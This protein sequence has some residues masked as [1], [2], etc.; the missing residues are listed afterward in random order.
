VQAPSR[1]Q[2]H[3][4]RTGKAAT[5]AVAWFTLIASS[6]VDGT[7]I[8]PLGWLETVVRSVQE[9]TFSIA[10][11]TTPPGYTKQ[12]H[13]PHHT[14]LNAFGPPHPLSRCSWDSC[15]ISPGGHLPDCSEGSCHPGNIDQ[16]HFPHRTQLRGLGH[17]ADHSEAMP[18]HGT[19]PRMRP[20][21]S[22]HPNNL[23]VSGCHGKT[24]CHGP[25]SCCQHRLATALWPTPHQE[26]AAAAAAAAAA[27]P[28]RIP[29]ASCGAGGTL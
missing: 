11:K 19:H 29:S 7:L 8:Q 23:A 4:Q 26:T 5:A 12:T 16:T 15:S 14:R 27:R 22:P 9:G 18:V 24:C 28:V 25:H 13:F 1:Q 20:Q 17:R 6:W 10:L 2:A 3:V 21:P